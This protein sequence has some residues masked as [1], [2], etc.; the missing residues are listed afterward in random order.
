MHATDLS[1]VRLY[2]PSILLKALHIYG[3]VRDRSAKSGQCQY[4]LSKISA[5][6]SNQALSLSL[7]LNGI[8]FFLALRV[9]HRITQ[10]YKGTCTFR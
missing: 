7:S 1:Q 3:Q 8:L 9:I 6:N 5:A 2:S 10:R 4:G